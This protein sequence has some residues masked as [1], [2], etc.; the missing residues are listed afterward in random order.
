MVPAGSTV[1]TQI[2]LRQTG[3]QDRRSRS[4]QDLLNRLNLDRLAEV[5][6]EEGEPE[7]RAL[8]AGMLDREYRTVPLSLAEREGLII[9]VL[10]ELFGLG[11]LEPLLRDGEFSDILVN[12]FDRVYV[13]RN[14]I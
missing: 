8:I 5:K 13:E 10:N 4:H 6:R 7:I 3:Y 14:E 9:D 2:D 1:L 12:R 11:P